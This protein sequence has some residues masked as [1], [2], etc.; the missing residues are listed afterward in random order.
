HAEHHQ[1]PASEEVGA[2]EKGR[3]I[4]LG[5]RAGPLASPTRSQPANLLVAGDTNI[6]VDVGDG[7]SGR[8]AALNLPTAR[9]SAI[10]ISHLHWDHT[11]GLAAILGLRAQ[12][13]SPPRLRIYGPPG[14]A[15]LVAG[16]IASMVPGA[17]AGYGVAGAAPT[18][19]TTLA[20]VI[21]LRDNDRLQYA[22]MTVSARNNTHYSFSPDSDLAGRFE[23]LSFRFDLPGRSIVYTGDTGPSAAVEEL[24]QGADLLVA[25]MMDVADTI[26]NV[27]RNNPAMP[28]QARIA[29]ERHLSDHHLL[30]VDVGQLASRAGVG[31]VVVTHFIGRERGDPAHFEY[32][33]EIAEH[34]DGPVV[35]ANDLDGF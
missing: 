29:M 8:L 20:E 33:R 7:T 10:F 26:A 16:L 32:L 6:L 18:D 14:T 12:T 2:L 31:G 22:G 23:S 13:N 19:V 3:W 21:E 27:R 35:I 5:T 17:T 28:D 25:E 9:V 15:E 34:Y 4:T 11:G 1:A 30:P 24:A